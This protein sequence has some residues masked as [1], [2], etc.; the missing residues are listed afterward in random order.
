LPL[1]KFQSSCVSDGDACRLQQ[2][3]L[4]AFAKLRKASSRPHGTTRIHWTDFYEI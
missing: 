4:G 2:T 3:F 1:L